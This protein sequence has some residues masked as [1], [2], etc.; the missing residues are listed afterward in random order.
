MVRGGTVTET[1]EVLF[2]PADPELRRDPY[3]VYRRLRAAAPAWRSPEGVWYFSRYQECF[4]L[5]RDPALSYD[6]TRTK[7]FLGTLSA[8]P[9]RREGQLAE[10]RASRTVLEMDP[11]EHTRVRSLFNQAFTPRTLEASRPLI[12]RL[13]DELLDGLTGPRIDVVADFAVMVP[14]LVICEML[15]VP[16][17]ERHTFAAIGRA[18]VA[19]VDPLVPPDERIAASRRLR[20]YI[21]A[22][23]EVRRQY[24]GDDLMSRLIEAAE[25]GRMA[26]EDEL[27]SNTGLLLI[28]GFETTTSLISNA[29]YQLIRHPAQRAALADRPE[30]I[31]AAIEETLRY[32]GPVHMMRPRT[33][34]ADARIGDADLHAGDA[35]VPL[36]AAANRDPEEF[37]D[38]ETFDISREVNRHMGFGL[39]HHMCVGAAL[40]RMEAQTVVPRIFER[41]PDLA[42]AP[43][44]QPQFRPNLTVRGLEKLPVTLW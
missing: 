3:P 31:R 10:F 32:D 8:D 36:I 19:T 29:I 12:T 43:D 22:L 21:A 34:T 14:V 30:L 39:G 17:E 40:A 27:L 18:M 4:A 23:V 44:E 1:A 20:D 9:A 5:F 25:D 24:P 15:G 41:F 35:V 6:P 38:P 37:G 42:F 28:A 33:I 7:T 2:D 16:P 26:T 11:P 13:A